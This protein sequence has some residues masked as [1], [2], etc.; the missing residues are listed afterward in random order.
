MLSYTFIYS[1]SRL[2]DQGPKGPLVY[3]MVLLTPYSIQGDWHQIVFSIQGEN[4]GVL[5]IQGEEG[6]TPMYESTW[7]NNEILVRVMS[8]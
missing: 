4:Y 3:Q 8:C 1:H 2:N 6:Y 5:S 7:L